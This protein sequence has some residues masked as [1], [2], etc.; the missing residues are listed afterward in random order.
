M[1]SHGTPVQ[2]IE[3]TSYAVAFGDPENNSLSANH[4][5][6]S[7]TASFAPYPAAGGLN[8]YDPERGSMALVID[9]LR[10]E[11]TGHTPTLSELHQGGADLPLLPGVVQ[12]QHSCQQNSFR[13]SKGE[14]HDW[15]SAE[16]EN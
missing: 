16:L 7:R 2:H 1:T 5:L 13:P 11:P 10:R 12:L 3:G 6:A 14:A 15:V 8:P 4:T 9:K